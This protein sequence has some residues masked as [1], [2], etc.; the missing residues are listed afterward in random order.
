MLCESGPGHLYGKTTAK[1]RKSRKMSIMVPVLFRRQDHRR[2]EQP[3]PPALWSC[4]VLGLETGLVCCLGKVCF[5]FGGS[6]AE[7]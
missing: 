1:L 7:G 2:P 3:V 6:L 5:G 4:S